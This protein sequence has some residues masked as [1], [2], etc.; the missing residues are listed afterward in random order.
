MRFEAVAKERYMNYYQKK[1]IFDTQRR[2]DYTRG[3]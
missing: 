3:D 2:K 1:N